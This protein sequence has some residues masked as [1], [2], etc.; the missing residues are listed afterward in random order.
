MMDRKMDSL[1]NGDKKS[2]KKMEGRKGGKKKKRRKKGK[3]FGRT[4]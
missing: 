3:E 2:I 1:R 4:Q